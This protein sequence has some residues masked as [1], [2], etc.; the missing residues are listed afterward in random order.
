MVFLFLEISIFGMHIYYSYVF[1]C[2]VNLDD[3]CTHKTTKEWHSEHL[4]F[5]VERV[6]ADGWIQNPIKLM[7]VGNFAFAS[8]YVW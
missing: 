6:V 7:V 1:R 4:D 3:L 2:S 8:H 5:H